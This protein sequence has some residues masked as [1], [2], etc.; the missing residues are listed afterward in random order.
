M[1]CSLFHKLNKNLTG[2]S[3]NQQ[4]RSNKSLDLSIFSTH[5]FPSKKCK[6]LMLDRYNIR[7]HTI[8]K[9]SKCYNLGSLIS[10]SNSLCICIPKHLLNCLKSALINMNSSLNYCMSDSTY[11]FTCSS[12]MYR[13]K[14]QA[15]TLLCNF[16]SSLYSYIQCKLM[17]I[18]NRKKSQLKLTKN[19]HFRR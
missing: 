1:N 17:N 15:S 12:Y 7:N 16:C 11:Y 6:A 3:K 10:F 13:S 14:C 5:S 4:C 2:L 19:I 9:H 8:N 18:F